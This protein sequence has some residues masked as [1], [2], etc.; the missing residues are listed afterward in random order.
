MKTARGYVVVLEMESA[1]VVDDL[2]VASDIMELLSEEFEVKSVN[3][4]GGDA[5]TVTPVG[6]VDA[7]QP[8]LF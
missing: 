8:E 6:N 2:A 7:A 4:H 5:P 1:G 3:P